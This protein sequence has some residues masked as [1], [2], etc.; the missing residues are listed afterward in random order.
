MNF[1]VQELAEMCGGTV[2]GKA[3]ATISGAASV[4]EA[5]PGEITFYGNPR[6]LAAFRRTRASAAFVPEDF[7]EQI[8]DAQ[9]RVTDP[10]KAFEQAV[11]KFAP[12]ADH[13]PAGDTSDRRP[14]SRDVVRRGG[15]DRRPCRRGSGRADW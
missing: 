13:L 8:V 1:T 9:I 10:T 15:F 6:Y 7:E 4:V 11:F 12:E 2:S 5:T 14:R 3:D